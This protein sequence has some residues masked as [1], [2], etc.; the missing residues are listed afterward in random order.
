MT[1]LVVTQEQLQALNLALAAL[2]LNTQ[3]IQQLDQIASAVNDYHPVAYTARALQL[4][5]LGKRS[6]TQATV[7][8]GANARP[9]PANANAVVS[10]AAGTN[11]AAAAG[12]PTKR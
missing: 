6:P 7:P 4:K 5:A 12:N 2:G 10:K 1:S 3:D 11:T 8:A 9:A